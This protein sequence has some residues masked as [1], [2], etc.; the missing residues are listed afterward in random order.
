M[1][2]Y[3]VNNN[4]GNKIYIVAS[5]LENAIKR[6]KNEYKEEELVAIQYITRYIYI[7]E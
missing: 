7:G 5:T 1:N 6:Y 3:L 2:L 4:Y